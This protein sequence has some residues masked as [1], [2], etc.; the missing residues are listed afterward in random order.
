M[1]RAPSRAKATNILRPASRAQGATFSPD[2]LSKQQPQ[3]ITPVSSGASA[4]M[5]QQPTR[6][7]PGGARLLV[8]SAAGGAMQPLVGM[9]GMPL[10]SP[11][12]LRRPP[13]SSQFH[14]QQIDPSLQMGFGVFN[15]QQPPVS[16]GAGGGQRLSS[17]YDGMPPAVGDPS[18]V[19]QRSISRSGSR[20]ELTQQHQQGL[21]PRS[22]S[23]AGPPN[24]MGAGPGPGPGPGPGGMWGAGPFGQM[25]LNNFFGGGFGSLGGDMMNPASPMLLQQQQQQ[26]MMMMN[27][28]PPGG[29][30]GSSLQM[31]APHQPARPATSTGFRSSGADSD[32]PMVVNVARGGARVIG[33]M[34]AK[35]PGTDQPSFLNPIPQSPSSVLGA[36]IPEPQQGST[37]HSARDHVRSALSNNSLESTHSRSNS[38]LPPTEELIEAAEARVDR[39]IQDLEISNKSLLAVNSQLEARVKAQREQ[40]NELKKQMQMREPYI[41]ESLADNDVPDE[42]AKSALEYRSMPAAGKVINT[43]DMNEDDSQLTVGKSPDPQSAQQVD[44]TADS[45]GDKSSETI[46]EQEEDDADDGDKVSEQAA[47]A[48]DPDTKDGEDDPTAESADADVK[49]Q[50]AR[51]L[52][53]RLMVLALSSPEPVPTQVPASATDKAGSRIP[54]RTG[55]GAGAASNST[56]RPQSALKGGL[57]TPMKSVGTRISSFGV[58]SEN[59]PVRSTVVSPTPSGKASSLSGSAVAG[60]GKDSQSASAE[61]EQILDICR[62]LQQIL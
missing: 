14:P 29:R 2:P 32:S 59:T 38:M 21:P 37:S 56:A 47:D 49:L 27:N 50:E 43:I 16:A 17:Y 44:G 57:R 53:A 39:K 51:E 25:G 33:P 46:D 13:S 60:G 20:A 28:L 62:K 54:R 40:I 55:S 19:P 23:R 26:M 45:K 3:Q 41:S 12:G 48:I 9:P 34:R 36:L 42:D 35:Q 7:L 31:N 8:S 5:A 18:M 30:P 22:S 10:N 24:M 58:A 1:E 11:G 6:V 15:A 4:G 61:R 52:V